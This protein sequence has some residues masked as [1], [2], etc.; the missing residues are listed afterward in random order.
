MALDLSH[1]YGSDLQLAPPGNYA[2]VNDAVIIANQTI[3]RFLLTNP[4]DDVFN[5][6]FGLGAKKIIGTTDPINK[7]KALINRGL[8]T[9]DVVDSSQP[10]TV[11]AYYDPSTTALNVSIQY[12]VAGLNTQAK[13]QV[14]VE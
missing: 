5:P 7:I 13:V 12:Y 9:L 8:A 4:G 6:A 11:G 10:F 2:T 14:T 3:T 1:N